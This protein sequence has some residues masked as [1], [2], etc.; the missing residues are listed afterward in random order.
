MTSS[1]GGIHLHYSCPSGCFTGYMWGKDPDTIRQA[2]LRLQAAH[3][4]P[5]FTEVYDIPPR[6]ALSRRVRS[7][8]G[9]VW[10]V[11]PD[12]R[13][14]AG[15]DQPFA[16]AEWEDLFESGR[17]LTLLPKDPDWF[18]GDED[19]KDVIKAFNEGEQGTTKTPVLL[20]P[21]WLTHSEV[22]VASVSDLVAWLRAH[23]AEDERVALEAIA[24]IGE[25]D[26]PPTVD[27]AGR[28]VLGN[29]AIRAAA[30]AHIGRH[31]PRRVLAEVEVK[32]AIVGLHEHRTGTC[33]RWD[34]A[35]FDDAGGDGAW[36]SED[37]PCRTVRLLA[38][39]YAD[40]PV[41]KEEGV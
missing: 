41:A 25:G 7:S 20:D 1:P 10:T 9:T 27:E 38:S 16:T 14:R 5:E 37:V 29:R 33:L 8:H 21:K 34:P 11:Q 4:G 26:G 18:E 23:L 40:W 15:E 35:A 19:P 17:P 28:A 13:L 22:K 32:R 24:D 2:F 36:V 31:T 12:G 6:P 3:N 30:T 39:A